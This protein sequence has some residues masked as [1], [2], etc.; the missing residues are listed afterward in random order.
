MTAQLERPGAIDLGFAVVD[1]DRERRQGLAE[2]VYA[3]GKTVPQITAIAT[4]LLATQTG[5]VLVSRIDHDSAQTV[6]RAVPGWTH[7]PDA[8]LLVWR[9]RQPRADAIRVAVVAAGTADRPIAREAAVVSSVLGASVTE[10]HD[11]GV[12]GL[13]RLLAR[14]DDLRQADVVIVVAGMEAALASAV[15][16]LVAVPVIAV[17]TSV[18]YGAAFEG[19]TALLGMLA[20]CS[21]GVTVVNIDSGFTAALAGYRMSRALRGER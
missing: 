15:A 3:P 19:I 9:A 17:P 12:A 11:V 20:G 13:H 21:A 8:R 18:G 16:G 5:P 7:H 14:Q 10:I 2:V 6:G 4:T 1:V